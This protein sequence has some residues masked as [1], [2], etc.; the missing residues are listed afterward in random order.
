MYNNDDRH[1]ILSSSC[2]TTNEP[3]KWLAE[4]QDLG[5]TQIYLNDKS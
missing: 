2:V 4:E 3:N 1:P 5:L